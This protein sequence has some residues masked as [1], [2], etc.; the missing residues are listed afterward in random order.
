MLCFVE[1]LEMDG[2]VDEEVATGVL[3]SSISRRT[4]LPE[5]NLMRNK[6]PVVVFNRERDHRQIERERKPKFLPRNFI[7]RGCTFSCKV[8]NIDVRK[9]YA[10]ITLPRSYKLYSRKYITNCRCSACH[11]LT[12][13]PYFFYSHQQLAS[14]ST[15]GKKWNFLSRK[16]Q[17]LW[18]IF[19]RS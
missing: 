9:G 12:K 13:N 6:T 1:L 10:D 2:V 11:Y 18:R 4:M 17:S 3:E 16:V 15:T 7:S 5:D 19:K 14:S 8:Q